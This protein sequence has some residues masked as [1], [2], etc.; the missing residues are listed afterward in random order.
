MTVVYTG[1]GNMIGYLSTGVWF[2]VCTNAVGTRWT[3]FWGGLALAC[4]GVLIYFLAV[5]KGRARENFSPRS[6]CT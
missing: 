3:T 6:E 2:A 4:V 1:A 5:Y